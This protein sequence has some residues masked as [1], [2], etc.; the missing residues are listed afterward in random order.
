MTTRHRDN[1]PHRSQPV[2]WWELITA[3][4]KFRAAT[5][6]GLAASWGHVHRGDYPA[7]LAQFTDT[8]THHNHRN[9]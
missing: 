6:M 7:A 4:E 2:L 8:V 3:M 9:V 5:G 1:A